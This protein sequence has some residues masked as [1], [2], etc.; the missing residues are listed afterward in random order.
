MIVFG[1]NVWSTR[2][3]AFDG[4]KNL[5]SCGDLPVG[6]DGPVSKIQFFY[7]YF[8]I[9]GPHSSYAQFELPTRDKSVLRYLVY[10]ILCSMQVLITLEN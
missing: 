4:K 9:I 1:R 5:Y 2:H 7:S 10:F 3:P 6:N 8:L